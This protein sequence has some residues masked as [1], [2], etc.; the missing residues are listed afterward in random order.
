MTIDEII[1]DFSKEIENCDSTESNSIDIAYDVHT[2]VLIQ[3]VQ[4]VLASCLPIAIHIDAPS[5]GGSVGVSL[6][7]KPW[8]RKPYAIN[9]SFDGDARRLPGLYIKKTVEG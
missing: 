1:S 7:Y 6:M 2:D 4:T 3:L 8:Y 9:T 5:G